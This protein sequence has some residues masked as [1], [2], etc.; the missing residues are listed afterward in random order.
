LAGFISEAV[1]GDFDLA[2]GCQL[3]R[4]THKPR[5]NKHPIIT[6]M[7]LSLHYFELNDQ[8]QEIT[9][10]SRRR[11]ERAL[12]ICRSTSPANSGHVLALLGDQTDRDYPIYRDAK[13]P[14]DNATLCS[15]L[16]DLD[17]RELRIYWD[18]PIKEPEKYVQFAL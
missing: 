12:T 13:P 2:G 4:L 6:I 5:R 1:R 8:E 14:D 11:L 3:S 18:H 15:G 16:Y 9:Q 7:K 17:R 10:S